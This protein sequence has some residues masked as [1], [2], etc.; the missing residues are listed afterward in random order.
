[1]LLLL[2]ILQI[3]T[4]QNGK[5][6]VLQTSQ[7]TSIIYKAPNQKKLLLYFEECT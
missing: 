4:H 2:K 5:K 1:M 7:E 6:G 3:T